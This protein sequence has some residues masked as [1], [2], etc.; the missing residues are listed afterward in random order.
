MTQFRFK[1]RGQYVIGALAIPTDVGALQVCCVGDSKADALIR[2]AAVAERISQDPV[3]RA[4][5]P[6]QATAAIK[7]SKA[8]GV[9]AKAG[10]PHLKRLWRQLRGEGKRRLAAVLHEEAKQLDE[11]AA[12]TGDIMYPD[13][14]AWQAALDPYYGSD[15]DEIPAAYDDDDDA[16]G[17]LV[18]DVGRWGRRKKKRKLQP[19]RRDNRAPEPELPEDGDDADDADDDQAAVVEEG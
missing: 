13:R 2:A 19:K 11:Q 5:L 9:A 1:V 17:M 3:M 6:P 8:L 18:E 14:G 4:L 15:D 16:D 12:S 7:A 10:A